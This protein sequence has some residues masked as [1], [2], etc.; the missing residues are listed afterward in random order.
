MIL[1]GGRVDR[2][3]VAGV[4]TGAYGVKGWLKVRSFT[5]PGENL[6]A[7]APWR[8]A[9]DATEQTREVVAGR[10]H[11]AG[12]VVQLAGVS[13]R[14]QAEALSGR[15][16]FVPR[17]ALPE[18][19]ENEYYHADL[20]GLEVVNLEGVAFGR[21]AW[22]METGANDV[23]VV[24]GDRERLVPFI[25]GAAVRSVN[26]VERRIVVDWDADF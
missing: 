1:G 25:L 5:E 12:L 3:I 6:L 2:L 11:G 24:S 22:V 7:Y 21:V 13:D 15:E 16:I 14:D 26:L 8:L 4:I 10:V 17:S 9:R 23:L 20:M 19:G 18:P